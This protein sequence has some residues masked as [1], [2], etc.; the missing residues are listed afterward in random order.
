VVGSN[1][2]ITI[3]NAEG[4]PIDIYSIDGGKVDSFTATSN[5][6][7]RRLSAG[8]YIV[9]TATAITKVILK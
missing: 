3:L 4:M 2:T 9:K 1:A 7:S 8:I 5:A 6:E